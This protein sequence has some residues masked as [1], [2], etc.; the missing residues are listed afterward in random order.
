M[1]TSV[2]INL[3]KVVNLL[4]SMLFVFWAK[5][6]ILGVLRTRTRLTF[7]SAAKCGRFRHLTVYVLVLVF[8]PRLVWY[9]TT[10]TTY[11]PYLPVQLYEAHF[12]KHVPGQ[13]HEAAGTGRY[14]YSPICQCIVYHKTNLYR[15]HVA[16]TLR[17]VCAAAVF[18]AR[19][20]RCTCTLHSCST[21]VPLPHSDPPPPDGMMCFFVSPCSTPPTCVS[22]LVKIKTGHSQK[23]RESKTPAHS[24]AACRQLHRHVILYRR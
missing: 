9:R 18:Y 4:T 15:K 11:L 1:H 22:P 16:D 10:L 12:T 14:M 24:F 20:K 17:A 13:H 19:A 23:P 21:A 5:T 6:Y 3:R 7:G 8:I 2:Q